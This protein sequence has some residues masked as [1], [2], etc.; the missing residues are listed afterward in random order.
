M[1]SEYFT[2]KRERC[3]NSRFIVNC[4]VTCKFLSLDTGT[5]RSKID[6]N[7]CASDFLFFI[8]RKWVGCK[9]VDMYSAR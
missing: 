9:R 2:S 1:Y 5:F 4:S 6:R 3:E 7:V 8:N